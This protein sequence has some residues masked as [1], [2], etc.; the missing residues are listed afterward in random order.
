MADEAALEAED[1][2]QAEDY[3]DAADAAVL[4]RDMYI[5]LKTGLDAWNVRENILDKNLVEYDPENFDKT[6]ELGL[7]AIG[8]Y[9]TKTVTRAM[10]SARITYDQ[11]NE[12]Y[13]VGLES[14][15]ADKGTT[16]E[17]ERQA[18]LETKAN[19]AVR[20]DYEA[21]YNVLIQAHNAFS[22]KSYEA[23]ADFFIRAETLFVNARLA[24]EEKRRIAQEALQAAEL[25][26]IDSDERARNVEQILEG[27]IR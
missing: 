3:Y 22:E 2:Y 17:I 6:D 24:A 10:E 18:A 1:K 15:A 8:D 5:A 23:A 21:A 11:Y 4:A 14:F 13:A 19:V 20:N 27:G 9:E 25:K 26:M 7:S 16:A 12:V